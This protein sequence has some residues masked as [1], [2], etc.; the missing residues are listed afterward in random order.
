MPDRQNGLQAA[1]LRTGAPAAATLSSSV[2]GADAGAGGATRARRRS[3]KV[4]S[5][6]PGQN[7]PADDHGQYRTHLAVLRTLMGADRSLMAWIRTAL[8]LVGFGFTIYKFLQAYVAGN[9]TLGGRGAPPSEAT[10]ERN[11]ELLFSASWP[12]AM[13]MS[14]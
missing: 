6:P 1:D 13:T 14:T 10:K 2:A 5:A 11:T 9:G 12:A 3:W 4:F 8:S 7:R